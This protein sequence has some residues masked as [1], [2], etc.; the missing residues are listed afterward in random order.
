MSNA[1]RCKGII[2]GTFILCGEMSQCS[3][4][5][6]ALEQAAALGRVTPAHITT[7]RP[8]DVFV[9]GSNEAGIHGTGAAFTAVHFGARRSVPSGPSG[10][11]YAIPTKPRD[12]TVSLC[13]RDISKY[14][15]EFMAY[16]TKRQDRCFLVTEIGCGLAGY[17]PSQIAP[18]FEGCVALPHVCLPQQFW[19]VLR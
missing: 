9:F 3:E 4:E 17:Q 10:K 19:T 16:A 5:C 12:I 7:L 8:L 11:T 13:L 1:K 14:V 15:A 2:P 6:W 18:M